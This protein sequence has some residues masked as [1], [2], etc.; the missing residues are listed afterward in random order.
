MSIATAEKRKHPR[1]DKKI[2]LKICQRWNEV[3]PDWTMVTS[4][5]ISA[6]GVLFGCGS[7]MKRGTPLYLTMYFP[8]HT[9]HCTGIV[10]RSFPGTHT[11]LSNVAVSFRGLEKEDVEL[12]DAYA[13]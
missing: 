13:A 5:N 9:I 4:K 7:S 6:G 8:G 2:L 11:P 12:I 1:I 10:E 3:V